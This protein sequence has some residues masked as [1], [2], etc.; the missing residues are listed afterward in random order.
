MNQEPLAP[1]TRERAG[2]IFFNF[3]KQ[4]YL[5]GDKLSQEEEALMIQEMQKDFAGINV[6]PEEIVALLD[7]IKSEAENPQS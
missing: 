3:A 6:S 2:E 5:N 4:E 1:M 7:L